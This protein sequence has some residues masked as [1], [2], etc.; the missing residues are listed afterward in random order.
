MNRRFRYFPG[1]FLLGFPFLA[2]GNPATTRQL[3]EA[4]AI[5]QVQE[6]R[7]G[8]TP[9]QIQNLQETLHML[10]ADQIYPNLFR[11]DLAIL[12][13]RLQGVQL[14]RQTATQSRDAILL[15]NQ[16]AKLNREYQVLEAQYSAL[17]QKLAQKTMSGAQT[18]HLEQKIQ[19]QE[20]ALKQ[21]EGAL[22]QMKT[23]V[24]G[25]SVSSPVRTLSAYGSVQSG[26]NGIHL[27]MPVSTLFQSS[28]VLS[29]RGLEQLRKVASALQRVETSEILVRVAPNP[30]GT[31]LATQRAERILRTLRKNGIPDQ[32]LALAT[33]S[34]L[35]DGTAELFLVNAPENP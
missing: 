22:A 19:Q 4:T 5:V 15:K 18:Q 29:T 20:Q 6:M 14:Y 23:P 28:H 2:Q 21:E 25:G 17:R 27:Q 7:G 35:P 12:E 30:G 11:V 31:N 10:T 13:A 32:R 16:M 34:G 8:L 3:Q 1:L 24:S 9:M 26:R 33:G